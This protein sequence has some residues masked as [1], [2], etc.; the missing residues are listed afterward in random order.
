MN[1]SAAARLAGFDRRARAAPGDVL[2]H[3]TGGWRYIAVHPFADDD[4][5]LERL[6]WP[7]ERCLSVDAYW[8]LAG[9]VHFLQVEAAGQGVT[10]PGHY[11]RWSGNA[12]YAAY[13]VAV[14]PAHPIARAAF[15]QAMT[16]FASALP[17]LPNTRTLTALP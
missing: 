17:H 6:Q 3:A 16:R 1:R 8:E 2:R 7:P 4:A 14:L 10:A 12:V 9:D 13:L 5:L 15:E 11:Y